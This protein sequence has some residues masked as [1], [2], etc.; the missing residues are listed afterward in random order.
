VPAILRRLPIL[1]TG[2]PVTLP[3]GETVPMLPHQIVMWVSLG[4]KGRRT[5][6]PGIPRFPAVLDTGFNHNFLLRH[7]HLVRWA[8][9]RPEQFVVMDRLRAYG[10]QVPLYAANV[11]VHPNRSGER[12]ELTGEPPFCL[13]LDSGVGVCPPALT[14]PRL[15]LLG[16]RALLVAGLQAKLDGARGLFSLRTPR[17]FWLFG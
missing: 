17:R 1:P 7:K 2:Q 6:G 3:G 13:E 10:Q 14:T 12:D 11:W 9:W 8:G 15:P 16:L 4:R 5:P